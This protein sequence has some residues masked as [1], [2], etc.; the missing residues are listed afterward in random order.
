[1]SKNERFVPI[2]DIPSSDSFSMGDRLTWDFT[3]PQVVDAERIVVDTGLL[4]GIQCIADFRSSHVVE[5]TGATTRYTPNVGS[6]G[7]DGSATLGMAGQV[8]KAPLGVTSML[9][10]YGSNIIMKNAGQTRTVHGLNRSELLSRVVD[11]LRGSREKGRAVT[12]EEVWAEQ[13][14]EAM[15]RSVRDASRKHLMGRNAVRGTII[16]AATYAWGI[17]GTAQLV[18]EHSPFASVIVGTLAGMTALT[19]GV[20][21]YM[22]RRFYGSTLLGERR[23]SMAFLGGMQPDRHLA[24]S[25]LTRAMPLVRARR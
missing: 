8:Q 21:S 9:D 23:W 5:Y 18:A 25:A 2:S 10:D 6:L 24:V 14:N 7:A 16:D 11:D 4:R 3:L 20:E 15:S 22:Y 1:M 13:L 19:L 12:R 17:G